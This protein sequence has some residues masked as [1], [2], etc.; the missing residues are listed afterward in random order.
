M[1]IKATPEEIAALV[2][3]IQERRVDVYY[4]EK[5]FKDTAHRYLWANS[6]SYAKQIFGRAYSLDE[7]K[8]R[9]RNFYPGCVVNLVCVLF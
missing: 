6:E 9:A 1:D 5:N 3:A 7:I 2:V 4:C 8:R